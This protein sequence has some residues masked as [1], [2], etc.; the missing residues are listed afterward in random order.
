MP[1]QPEQIMQIQVA[2]FVKQNTDIPFL[3]IPNEAKRSKFLGDLLKRMGMYPGASDCFMPRSNGEYK[4]LWIEL[5]VKPNKPTKNQLEFMAMMR[6]E[7]YQALVAYSAEEAIEIISNFYYL[8][9]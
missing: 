9:Y 8:H 2:E 3:H 4:G 7:G 5:K 6:R 1:I